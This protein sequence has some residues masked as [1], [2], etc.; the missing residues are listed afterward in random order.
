MLT[1]IAQPF[2]RWMEESHAMVESIASLENQSGRIRVW[3]D[4]LQELIKQQ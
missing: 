4:F 3:R 1:W 2:F